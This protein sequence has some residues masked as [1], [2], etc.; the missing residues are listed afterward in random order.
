MMT[1]K[2]IT[3]VNMHT[4]KQICCFDHIVGTMHT[5]SHAVLWYYRLIAIGNQKSECSDA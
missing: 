3:E 1:L 4:A 2:C 5:S